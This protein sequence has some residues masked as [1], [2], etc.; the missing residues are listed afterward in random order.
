MSDPTTNAAIRRRYEAGRILNDPG[1][2][3][4][5]APGFGTWRQVDADRSALLTVEATAETDGTS[6]GEVLLDVDE[7]GGTTADYTLTIAL[8][9]ADN[10][11]GVA[12]ADALASLYLPAGAQYQIR[13]ASDP[14]ANNTIDA[15]R[16][17]TL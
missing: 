10:A 17:V 16:E 9:D 7:S 15:V 8:S 4:G 5:V 11:A 6:A 1:T 14:N 12:L 13:N 2:T 3:T